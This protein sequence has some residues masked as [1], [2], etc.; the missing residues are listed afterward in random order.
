EPDRLPRDAHADL[1]LGTD[2]HELDA[3][4]ERLDDEAVELVAAVVADVLAEEA[5]RHADAELAHAPRNPGT[6]RAIAASNVAGSTSITTRS[7]VSEKSAVT[8]ITCS[9]NFD[10]ASTRARPIRV[11]FS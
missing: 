6:S 9:V 3:A 5:R 2:R 1:E 10:P 11:L 4:G 8:A 7:L